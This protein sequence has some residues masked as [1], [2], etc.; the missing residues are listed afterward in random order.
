MLVWWSEE[1]VEKRWKE[2]AVETF[3]EAIY[4]GS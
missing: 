4:M 3:D 2:Y 1:I